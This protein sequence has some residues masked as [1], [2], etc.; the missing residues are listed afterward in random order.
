MGSVSREQM[1]SSTF[2][3]ERA[4]LHWLLRMSLRQEMQRQHR[5]GAGRERE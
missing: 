1:E 3:M 5:E 4:G 2:E